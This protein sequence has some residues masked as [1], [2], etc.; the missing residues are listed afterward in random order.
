MEMEE[1]DGKESIKHNGT[2]L[3]GNLFKLGRRDSVALPWTTSMGL[4]KFNM[5][6]RRHAP[7]PATLL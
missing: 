5:E 6:T 1:R 7:F 4:P 3:S 2:S